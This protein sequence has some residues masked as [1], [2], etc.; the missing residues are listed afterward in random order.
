MATL[1][2]LLTGSLLA[3]T[4]ACGTAL[5]VPTTYHVDLTTVPFASEGSGYLELSLSGPGS[6]APVT[7]MVGNL[8]GTDTG[9]YLFGA[10]QATGGDSYAFYTPD[11]ALWKA[12]T[13]GGMLGFDVTFDIGDGGSD[14][15]YFT[16]A[17]LNQADYLTGP[18][19]QF[20]LFAGADP[21]VTGSD[22]ALVTLVDQQGEV[23]EPADWAMLLTGLGLMGF[24]LRRRQR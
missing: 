16:V 9:D 15:N 7:A 23:P 3:L 24:T 8:T 22:I 5:A 17:F 12:V 1:K 20:D 21:V 14:I 6:A 11:S 4:M 19:V 18:V 13:F 10:A 2:S